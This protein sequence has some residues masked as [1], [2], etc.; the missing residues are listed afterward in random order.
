LTTNNTD[1][2]SFLLAVWMSILQLT[3]TSFI[4]VLPE[5]LCQVPV[6]A[7]LNHYCLWNHSYVSANSSAKIILDGISSNIGSVHFTLQ[8]V[9]YSSQQTLCSSSNSSAKGIMTTTLLNPLHF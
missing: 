7:G 5:N 1:Y 8:A 3:V 9:I 4:N 2:T 6:W